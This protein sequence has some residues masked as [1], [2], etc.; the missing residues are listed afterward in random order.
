MLVV[1]VVVTVLRRHGECAVFYTATLAT[2]FRRRPFVACT[3]RNIFWKDANR[4]GSIGL[5]RR[6]RYRKYVAEVPVST[7]IGVEMVY[8]R[9]LT[10]R[11][12]PFWCGNERTAID[13]I[14]G[15][16]SRSRSPSHGPCNSARHLL[17]TLNNTV[18]Y[19]LSTHLTSSNHWHR[20]RMRL[21]QFQALKGIQVALQL[22]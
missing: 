22:D 3:I 14:V 19:G 15:R 9:S 8:G 5:G 2:L 20:C 13:M 4:T 18:I 16:T 7:P 12:C 6:G 21:A 10:V 11:L 17:R 1:V